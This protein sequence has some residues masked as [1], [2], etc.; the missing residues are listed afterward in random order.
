NSI[1]Q[2]DDPGVKGQWEIKRQFALDADSLARVLTRNAI[3]FP[4]Y[5]GNPKTPSAGKKQ[6]PMPGNVIEVYNTNSWPRT[7]VVLIP[8]SESNGGDRV[9]D[10]KHRAVPSQRLSTGELAMLVRDIP[11]FSS[12][13]F[14]LQKGTAARMGRL[15]VSRNIL[16]NDSLALEVDD[17]TG[18]I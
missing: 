15:E 13:R 5:A 6:R 3:T 14:V 17:S 11:P 12:R 2:P 7:D 1:E 9:L 4:K 18:A 10:S 16:R 8:R